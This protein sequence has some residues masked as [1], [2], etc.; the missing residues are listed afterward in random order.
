MLGKD[1]SFWGSFIIICL[2]TII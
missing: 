1:E 2:A